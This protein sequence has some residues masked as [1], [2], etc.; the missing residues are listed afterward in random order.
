MKF[1]PFKRKH[2]DEGYN[3]CLKD[4]DD[5]I[6]STVKLNN[7]GSIENVHDVLN[8]LI[9]FLHIKSKKDNEVN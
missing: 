5:Q 6:K 4:M 1:F 2:F 7:I 3:Q 9:L 8:K